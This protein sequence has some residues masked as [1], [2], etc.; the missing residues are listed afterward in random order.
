MHTLPRRFWVSS[1]VILRRAYDAG[2]L[3]A[4]AFDE[5]RQTELSKVEKG[6]K[7]KG[8]DFYRNL[9]VRMGAKFTATVIAEVNRE[10]IA[11]SQAA[12]LLGVSG[13]TLIK[14]AEM[15]R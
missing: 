5:L 10:N 15:S 1:L 12:K 11:V 14:Y 3:T 4:G 9:V 6:T 13:R 2:R 8:G 7:P